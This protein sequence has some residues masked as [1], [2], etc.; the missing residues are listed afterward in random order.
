LKVTYPTAK[1]D[2]ARLVKARILR[3]L[4][5]AGQITFYAPKVYD[6]AYRDIE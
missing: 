6:A 3:E 1:A 2:I 5:N 4:P